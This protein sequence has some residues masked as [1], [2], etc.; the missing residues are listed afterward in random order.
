MPYLES[1]VVEPQSINLLRWQDGTM[2]GKTRLVPDFKERFGAPYYVVHRAHLHSALHQ[3]AMDLNVRVI[4]NSR[5]DRYAAAT[6]TIVLTN[7]ESH[8]SDLVIAADGEC[9]TNAPKEK[10]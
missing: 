10:Y 5:V 3:R 8:S 1:Y 2:I 7:G 6:G 9:H 4:L